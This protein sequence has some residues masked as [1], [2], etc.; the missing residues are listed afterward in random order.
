MKK[1]L[2]LF[3]ICSA[4]IANSNIYKVDLFKYAEIVS[5][6]SRVNILIDNKV[7]AKEIYFYAPKNLSSK[8]Y[9]QSFRDLLED[10][11][12][13]LIK[14]SGYYY[15]TLPSE[16]IDHLYRYTFE[17]LNIDDVKFLANIFPDIKFQF[18]KNS[19]TL[20][21]RTKSIRKNDVFTICRSIDVPYLSKKVSLT[22]FVTDL[23]KAKQKGFKADQ[24]GI[25]LS[26][27]LIQTKNAITLSMQ[28]VMKFKASLD[29]LQKNKVI[30]V[31]QNPIVH[32]TDNKKTSFKSVKNIPVAVSSTSIND[33]KITT[34]QNIEYRDIGFTIDIFPEV[35]P[36]YLFLDLNI[37]SETIDTMSQTPVTSKISYQNSFKLK[38]DKAILLTG[39]N[40]H[41]K[42]VENYKVPILGDL[43]Y[44]NPLFKSQTVEK[45]DQV[46]SILIE[47]V[48]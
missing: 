24:I 19:N 27:V 31:L 32:L 8:Q 47:I 33:N 38:P 42:T 40:L 11:K 6:A 36:D 20:F 22:I 14:R 5:S 15:V 2:I 39:F 28:N 18:F 48:Q 3:L 41:Q 21:F 43:P 26:N 34:Q 23:Q 44:I 1:L 30:E 17:N 46:L 10:V 13:R 35:Y 37:T 9:L 7:P 25:D 12:L 29:F 45:K 4:L 16:Y